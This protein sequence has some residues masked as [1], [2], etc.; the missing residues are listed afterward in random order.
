MPR[1]FV[2]VDHVA[3]VREARKIHYPSPLRAAAMAEDAGASGITVH[4]RED[5]RH[6]Q[7]HDVYEMRR[8][9]RT[10]FN[11]ECAV[12]EEIVAIALDIRP[13]QVTL[14][15]EKREEITTEGGLDLKKGFDR[16]QD[17]T[18][19]LQERGILVS[20][21]IDPDPDSVTLARDIGASHIELHT[22]RYANAIDPR[23]TARELS[24]LTQASDQA[25]KLGLK[26]N[27]GHGLHMGNTLAVAK[28]PG[29]R[30]LNIGHALIADAIFMGLPAAVAR[31]NALIS[32]ASQDGNVQESS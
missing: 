11:L 4:L 25:R 7:D 12:S 24:D 8:A 2:N 32:S 13:D 26:V 22:G 27:A 16:L 19:R 6:I 23:A 21:F 1:L 20:L 14:V 15:P 30:D 10:E 5:R 9:C 17:V 3:T 29:I 31:M 18:A 28:I